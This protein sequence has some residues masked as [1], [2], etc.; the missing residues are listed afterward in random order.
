MAASAEPR[1][2]QR[3]VEQCVGGLALRTVVGHRGHAGLDRRLRLRLGER[4]PVPGLHSQGG[5]P[6]SPTAAPAATPW[7]PWALGAVLMV[8]GSLDLITPPLEE[9]LQL[10]LPAGHAH[11]RL[12]LVEGGSHFSPVR[13]VERQEA[14]LR[15]GRCPQHREAFLRKLL[16]ERADPAQMDFLAAED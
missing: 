2:A 4:Q 13:M 16:A 5:S 15:L 8:G 6:S 3:S 10:F 1:H 9:Q 11:S 7:W 12:V 14:V